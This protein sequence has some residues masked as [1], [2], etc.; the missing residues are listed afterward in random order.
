[1]PY[2]DHELVR[3]LPGE[4]R[5]ELV[6][7]HLYNYLSFVA[8]LESNIVNDGTKLV[9]DD[10]L[11]LDIRQDVRLDAWKIY[12]D[13]AYHALGS[14]DLVQQVADASGVRPTR[15][16][17]APIH[18]RLN[19]AVSGL[20]GRT[21]GLGR[22]LQTVVYETTVTALLGD[23]PRDP[24]VVTA[25][26]ESV[27]DHARDERAHHAFYTMFFDHLWARLSPPTR[28]EAARTLP[29]LVRVCVAPDLPALARALGAVGLS[30]EAARQALV[31]TYPEARLVADARRAARH[32]LR[33]F[34]DHEVLEFPGAR[35]AFA[36]HGLLEPASE[37][38]ADDRSGDRPR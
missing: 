7:H 38:R 35:E 30:S 20:A 22:L 28:A 29:A 26:R 9:A 13:E 17:F 3:R 14:F 16:S 34:L 24:T 4:L 12:C 19:D 25:V 2:L 32:T 21:P 5:D 31:E 15:Y 10:E 33:M 27:G 23:I 1:M 18:E 37:E 11:G 36:A 8:G 6:V